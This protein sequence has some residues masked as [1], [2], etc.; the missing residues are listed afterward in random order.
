[1][2]SRDETLR[3]GDL[4]SNAS[5]RAGLGFDEAAKAAKLD[6]QFYVIRQSVS[7]SQL[8]ALVG[9]SGRIVRGEVQPVT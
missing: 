6:E 3:H 4:P 1:M 7:Q 5:L 8:R 9:L 2:P